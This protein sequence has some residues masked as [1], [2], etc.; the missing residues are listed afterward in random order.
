MGFY[1]GG[2]II[3]MIFASEPVGELNFG[4]IMFFFFFLGG[5]VGGL[6]SEF[7]GITCKNIIFS[8][9]AHCINLYYKL[10]FQFKW[11]ICQSWCF[12]YCLTKPCVFTAIFQ[13]KYIMLPF[14]TFQALI[15]NHCYCSFKI[16]C[17]H[18][19]KRGCSNLT[20]KI[21]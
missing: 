7:Y 18:F 6:L 12:N 8:Q 17:L 16:T 9:T 14:F 3:G 10:R 19:S 5:G 11:S 21:A 2:L 20:Q 15:V 1:L 4:C 13:L